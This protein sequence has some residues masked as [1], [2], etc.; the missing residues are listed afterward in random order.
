MMKNSYGIEIKV[1][2]A[3]CQYKDL[4]RLITARYCT[5]HLK[6]I[7]S[8]ECCNQWVLSKQLAAAGSA[9]GK[10]KRRAY[11]RYVQEVR[12]EEALAEQRGLKIVC[13]TIDQ[14]RLEFETNQGSIFL[15]P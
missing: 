1:C 11:L 10:V 8:N 5:Q 9:E 6:S 7:M 15:E 12:E 13:K 2:C 14:I 3:S 4:T